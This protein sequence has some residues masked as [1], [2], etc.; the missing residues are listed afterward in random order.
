MIPRLLEQKKW[1]AFRARGRTVISCSTRFPGECL[2]PGSV[3]R[4]W[5][6]QIMHPS[7]RS[8]M[9]AAIRCPTG[10]GPMKTGFAA[11]KAVSMNSGR[12]ALPAENRSKADTWNRMNRC[13]VPINASINHCRSARSAA[14]RFTMDFPLVIITTARRAASKVPPVFPAAFRPPTPRN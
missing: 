13:T 10:T 6:A 8:V 1:Y 9:S 12:T 5:S 4:L 11:L 3:A 7:P 2:R 14:N